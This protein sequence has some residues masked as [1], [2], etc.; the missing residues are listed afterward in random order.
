MAYSQ[1]ERAFIL[2]HHLTLK[3]ISAVGKE[4]NSAYSEKEVSSTA[5]M[6]WMVT[7][8]RDAGSV[9]MWQLFIKPEQGDTSVRI[10]NFQ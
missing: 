10:Q 3:S 9:C 5:T 6:Q 7:K 2:E 1:T 8:F 4:F